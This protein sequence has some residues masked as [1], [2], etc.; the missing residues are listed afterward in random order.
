MTRGRALSHQLP[1]SLLSFLCFLALPFIYPSLFFDYSTR[2]FPRPRIGPGTLASKGKPPPMAD[3]PV[4]AQVHQ[5][6]NI[7]CDFSAQ[8][9]FQLIVRHFRSQFIQL[10]FIQRHYLDVRGYPC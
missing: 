8:I 2:P 10:I 6:F 4:G 1:F 9:T 7:H 3:T 5:S